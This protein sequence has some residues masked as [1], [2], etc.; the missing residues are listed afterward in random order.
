MAVLG[1]IATIFGLLVGT[2]LAIRLG[3]L[4]FRG[5]DGLFNRIEDKF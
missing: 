4:V 2:K 1:F 5:M 3:K